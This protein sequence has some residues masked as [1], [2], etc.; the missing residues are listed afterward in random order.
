MLADKLHNLRSLLTDLELLGQSVWQRFNA[1]RDDQLWY[2][3]SLADAART[4]HRGGR[5]AHELV[6][7]V[8]Q[9]R[10]AADH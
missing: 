8:E 10:D 6:R 5:L 4:H 2:Y 9:L 1:G 3:A 7:S